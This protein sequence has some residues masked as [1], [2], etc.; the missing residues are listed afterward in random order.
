MS[1]FYSTAS[2]LLRVMFSHSV[3]KQKLVIFKSC[4]RKRLIINMIDWNQYIHKD[5]NYLRNHSFIHASGKYV[6]LA[7][8]PSLFSWLRCQALTNV[9]HR[10]TKFY[11][12]VLGDT[13]SRWHTFQKDVLNA[14]HK[15]I[16]YMDQL[17]PWFNS[18]SY[19]FPNTIMYFI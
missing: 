11:S 1:N 8:E 17:R 10:K 5:F 15:T 9:T 6:I 14:L 4:L 7:I 13:R 18:C 3:L 16:V 12:Q 19:C 2:I